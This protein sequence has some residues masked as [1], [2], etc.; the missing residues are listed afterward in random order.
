MTNLPEWVDGP[1]FVEWIARVRP[2]Y[3]AELSDSQRRA[4]L[5]FS[6][7]GAKGSLGAVDRICVALF[8]HLSEI[9][10]EVWSHDGP[11]KGRRL[12]DEV[13]REALELTAQGLGPTEIARRLRI[14]HRTVTKWKRRAANG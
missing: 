9:P 12:P 6:H 1:K 5:R 10:D 14:T 11:A 8:L 2:D 3:M 4:L 7:P 13:R